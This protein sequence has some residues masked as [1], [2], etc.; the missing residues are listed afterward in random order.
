MSKDGLPGFA[1]G[2]GRAQSRGLPTW[3]DAVAKGFGDGMHVTL[4]TQ[5]RAPWY[6]VS[7]HVAEY[8]KSL[9]CSVYNPNTDCPHKATDEVR[10]TSNWLQEFRD[11]GLKRSHS[12]KGFCL[13]L[14][15]GKRPKMGEKS[16]MQIAEE[17]QAEEILRCGIPRIAFCTWMASACESTGEYDADLRDCDWTQEYIQLGLLQAINEARKQWESG[18]IARELKTVVGRGG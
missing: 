18:E 14:Q 17:E 5:Y 2:E 13:Q 15:A 11:S 16:S 10:G 9:G 1:R 4:S 12:T 7:V 3:K 8:L 6:E